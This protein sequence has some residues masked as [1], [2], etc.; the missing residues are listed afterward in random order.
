[1]EKDSIIKKIYLLW[2]FIVLGIASST[3]YAV[4]VIMHPSV[5]ESVLTTSQ[6]RRIY[7]MRQIHWADGSRITVYTLPRKHVLHLHFSKERL[8]MFPYQLDRIWNKLTYSGL[9][10]AP[11]TVNSPQEL[12]DAI[13][14]TPGAIGYVDNV[15]DEE[16][17]RVITITD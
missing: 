3:V 16:S 14:N 9:G 5:K 10:V 6:L 11:I 1:M 17:V 8:Q 7:T 13:K 2:L 15:K 4:E 12:I